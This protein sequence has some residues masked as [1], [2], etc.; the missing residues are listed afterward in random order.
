MQG[1]KFETKL[2]VRKWADIDPEL[3]FRTFVSKVL[4]VNPYRLHSSS[5]G[6]VTGITQYHM[7]CYVPEFVENKDKIARKIVEK[8][9]ELNPLVEAPDNTYTIDFVFSVCIRFP[10]DIPE[11]TERLRESDADRN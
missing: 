1:G 3:E 7:K 6:N 5:Q 4:P 2:V 10:T 9:K 8:V 11:V